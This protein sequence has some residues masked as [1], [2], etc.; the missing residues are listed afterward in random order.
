MT[1][2][3]A[4]SLVTVDHS[5]FSVT[6][7]P[8]RTV[9]VPTTTRDDASDDGKGEF[10]HLRNMELV[11][12]LT[13]ALTFL[14]V[15][16]VLG[17]V[18]NTVVLVV[19]YRR[20]KASVPRV[21]ILAMA[22]CDFLTNVLAIPLQIVEIRF[23]V[24]FYATWGCKVI[25]SGSTALILFTAVILVAVAVDRQKVICTDRPAT[26][27]SVRGAY[28]A[29][30]IAVVVAVLGAWPYAVLAGDHVITFP[31]SNITGVTCTIADTYRHTAFPT[32]YIGV[33][34]LSYCVSVMIMVVSYARIA[35]HLW[36]HRE[37]TTTLNRRSKCAVANS[38]PP[39]AI[40]KQVPARTS[41]MLFVFT[42]LFIV[43]YFPTLAMSIVDQADP[44]TSIEDLERNARSILLRWHFVSSAVNP[45]V[46]S[47]VSCKFRHECRALVGCE[48]H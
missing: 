16:L 19:Y 1:T 3:T 35:R 25:R 40:V 22:V 36:Q 33:L 9:S 15:L 31:D 26:L 17:L 38:S 46:Y 2:N 34:A 7:D 28:R 6:D 45:L 21:Y 11:S 4:S 24:T 10:L 37:T 23:N 18:G 13:P 44:K 39:G 42:V 41:L 32:T 27:D 29:V 43:N 20:F 8:T 12:A 30:V 14:C 47:F 48:S 5:T